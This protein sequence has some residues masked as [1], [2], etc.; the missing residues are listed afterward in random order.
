M[1]L[2]PATLYNKITIAVAEGRER[3]VEHFYR[4]VVRHPKRIMAVFLLTAFCCLLCR[5][6]VVVNYDM[7]DY[8]PADAPSSMALEK[9]QQEFDGGIPNVRVMVQDVSVP[10]ALVYKE[11]LQACTGVT[12]VMWLDDGVDLHQPLEQMDRDTRDAYYKDGNALF[13][14]TVTEAE[15]IAAVDAMRTVIGEENAMSGEAVSSAIATRNTVEEIQKIVVVSV[16]FV[17]FLLVI[18]NQSW[19]DPL[20]LMAGLG[21]AIVINAGSNVI[22]GEISFVTNAAGS[23]LQLAV[24][25]DY[26]VFLLHRFD[27]CL[28]ESD[29]AQDAMVMALRKS[30]M[31]ILSSGLTTVIGFL[32]L[33]FMRFRI[34][35]DLGL[36]LAKGVVL[37][38]L[39][40]FVFMPVLILATQR[41]RQ[42]LRHRRFLPDF[43]P[44]GKFVSR[45][46][47]PMV[48]VFVLAV[49]PGYLASNANAFYYGSSHI[50]GA[51]TRLGRDMA[52]IE[53]TFGQSSNYVLMVPEGN[54]AAEQQ[55]SAALH[56][57]PQIKTILS[58]VDTVG[59]EVP[60]AYLEQDTLS[61]LVSA[62]YS[63]M[64]LTVEA[65]PEGAETF[66]LV[67]RL[68]Q[69][70][71]Q[72]YP[73]T[74]Y[75]AGESVSTYDLMDTITA[76]MKKVNF[77]AIGA[78]FL[79]LLL[80]FQSLVLPII[81]VLCIEAAIWLNLATP[82]FAGSTV[83]YISY[84]IISSIQL[85]ATV[86]YAIL[87]ADRYLEFRQSMAKGQ[88]IVETAATVT[89]SMLTSATAL[90]VIGFL[91]GYLSSHGILSQLGMFL[92][93]GGLLSLLSVLFV[94]PGL[95]YLLDGVIS[96]TSLK[97]RQKEAKKQ[98]MIV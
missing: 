48:C 78:V 69:I 95:L 26:S 17:L 38:L 32:A 23:I 55:L 58:Y 16:L 98:E 34:G 40:V 50:Y 1:V 65:E 33:V 19:L 21:I 90:I 47:L 14:V 37:S 5:N 57:V 51:D 73:G 52:A 7:K 82:Y 68:R 71:E 10:E 60:A 41:W 25:L 9:M 72:Y 63:R 28:A 18:T 66:A 31:S 77:I 70:A 61:R 93:R 94:L 29:T 53:D 54:S 13:T 4:W 36:A 87:F 2:L 79:V 3:I 83:F 22:F 75:L 76:D 62:D 74:Y 80:S 45:G 15:R 24:S 42:K 20:V 43:H 49:A 11:K 39:T 96:R 30:T 12:S 86:D 44:F 97:R 85:G 6:L 56:E 64:V 27:Q 91:L 92:G 88:A 67:E 46:M 81:L 8:L 89:V 35:P 84:L 59:A